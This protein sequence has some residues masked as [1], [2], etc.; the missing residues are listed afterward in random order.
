MSTLSTAC[1]PTLTKR[2]GKIVPAVSTSAT[3]SLV[4]QAQKVFSLATKIARIIASDTF[5]DADNTLLT[6]HTPDLGPSWTGG[7]ANYKIISNQLNDKSTAFTHAV[8]A[9]MSTEV[10][11]QVQVTQISPSTS[12]PISI[13][14]RHQ[15]A[16]NYWELFYDLGNGWQFDKVV[17]GVD[18]FLGSPMPGT[19]G[20]VKLK[21]TGNTIIATGPDGSTRTAFD[22]ALNTFTDVAI[23]MRGDGTTPSLIDNVQVTVFHFSVIKQVSKLLATVNTSNVATVTSIKVI[24]KAVG[25]VAT[26]CAVT[27]I[28]QANKRVGLSILTATGTSSIVR[29]PA[30]LV[31]VNTSN[32]VTISKLISKTISVASSEVATIIKRALKSLTVSMNSVASVSKTTNR[33]AFS[34]AT[35]NVVTLIKQ[36]NKIVTA[37]TSNVATVS[38]LKVFV[39]TIS[40]ATANLVMLTKQANKIV[41]VN[42]TSTTTIS[43]RANKILSVVDASTASLIKSAL[44]T[45]ALTA[46]ETPTITKRAN[47]NVSATA[48]GTSTIIRLTSKALSIVLACVISLLK[49]GQKVLPL[50]SNE[51][52]TLVKRAN[53]SII[54]TGT[55]TSSA[56]KLVQK[57]VTVATASTATVRVQAWKLLSV[58]SSAVVSLVKS[59][60]ISFANTASGTPAITRRTNKTLATQTA[61][62]SATLRKFILRNF[63]AI[64]T[65]TASLRVTAAKSFSVV[66]SSVVTALALVLRILLGPFR[67]LLANHGNSIAALDDNGLRRVKLDNDGT[68]NSALTTGA[69]RVRLDNDGTSQASLSGE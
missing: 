29:A 48:S 46:T 40:A 31:V 4:K 33:G 6:A 58:A 69:N 34:L 49:Q 65:A 41:S 5:T 23:I 67:A 36:V 16:A 11:F 56:A 27:L 24:L 19:T 32:V 18:N 1:I 43:R 2:P 13:M 25:L 22:S 68:G 35:A 64:A 66:S 63:A 47:K 37:A 54:A 60:R 14:V 28:K 9:G 7:D 30:K 44:K 38:A 21:A 57:N 12:V 52:V 50:T 62:G 39:R 55:G 42:S 51:A 53:K 45:F 17:S 15:N 3:V 59:A 61:S 26:A 8:W 20:T 10:E